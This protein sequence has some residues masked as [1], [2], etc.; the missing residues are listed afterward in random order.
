MTCSVDTHNNVFVA[1]EITS[2][3]TFENKCIK[4]VMHSSAA[5]LDVEICVPSLKYEKQDQQGRA[6]LNERISVL[7]KLITNCSY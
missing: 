6:A 3:R 2:Y 5:Q 4:I 7:R 1:N